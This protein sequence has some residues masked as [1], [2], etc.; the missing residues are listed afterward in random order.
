MSMKKKIGA[1][2]IAVALLFGMVQFGE[3]AKAGSVFDALAS[4]FEGPYHVGNRDYMDVEKQAVSTDGY[5]ALPARLKE[6][7]QQLDEYVYKFYRDIDDIVIPRDDFQMLL[8]YYRADHPQAFWLSSAYRYQYDRDSDELSRVTLSFSYLDPES[9]EEK[10]FTKSRTEEM[11]AELD[12]AADR[13]LAGVTEEMSEYDTVLYLHDYLAEQVDY[14]ET[15][16]YQHTAYGALV[17]GKAVCDGYAAAM[18]YLLLRAGIDCQI[19]YGDDRENNSEH[20][21]WNTVKIDGSWYHLD[22][23]W[24]VPPEGTSQALYANFL[25]STEQVER[26]HIIHSPIN[27]VE[28]EEAYSYYPPVENCTDEGLN[29]YQNNGLYVESLTDDSV[30]QILME[31]NRALIMGEEQ[32]QFQFASLYDLRQFIR[33]AQENVPRVAR[34]FP[35]SCEQ[36]QTKIISLQEDRILILH[37]DYA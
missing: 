27:G 2:L 3:L 33:E 35:Y 34:G 17:E 11:A 7:Y 21:A 8:E 13:V 14:D 24:D 18:Q 37:F 20:H 31:T 30:A 16:A 10:N 36:Y 23:T 22:V 5:D 28:N 1:A 9:G 6:A 19:V 4:A 26:R 25:L 32:V 12:E 15:S 29:Y